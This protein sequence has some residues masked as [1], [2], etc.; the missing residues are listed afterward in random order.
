MCVLCLM[1]MK[2]V[3]IR[4]MPY[5]GVSARL[6]AYFNSLMAGWIFMKFSINIMLFGVLKSLVFNLLQLIV[7][8]GKRQELVRSQRQMM[9]SNRSLKNICNFI[10]M[11]FFI[12]QKARNGG[13]MKFIRLFTFWFD[14]DNETL[15]LGMS[16]FVRRQITHSPT[17]YILFLSE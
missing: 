17:Y 12:K 11:R 13:W 1:C 9:Y 4:L 2:L 5:F 10:R 14:S 8:T 16:N 6:P 7:S 3:Y 15:E